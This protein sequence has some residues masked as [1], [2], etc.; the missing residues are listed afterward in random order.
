MCG[1]NST[2]TTTDKKNE[3]TVIPFNSCR[4]NLKQVLGQGD[5]ETQYVYVFDHGRSVIVERDTPSTWKMT[6]FHETKDREN[7]NPHYR[8]D[9]RNHQICDLD[10]KTVSYWLDTIEIE[11]RS[12]YQPC[13]FCGSVWATA[14]SSGFS[15]WVECHACKARGPMIKAPHSFTNA[16]YA[17]NKSIARDDK[18][19]ELAINIEYLHRRLQE[20]L[21]GE[22]MEEKGR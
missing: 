2:G 18:F 12:Y 19:R 10:E 1:N 21:E 17:W 5:D 15:T 22:D 20:L 16:T 6:Y 8:I 9:W 3:S 13:P 4:D 7:Q 11:S 14:F